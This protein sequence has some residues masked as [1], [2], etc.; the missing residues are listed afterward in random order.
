M[1]EWLRKQSAQWDLAMALEQYKAVVREETKNKV[2]D[3]LVVPTISE[4]DV[5][6]SIKPRGSPA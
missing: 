1:R 2:E 3:E 5:D 6:S 4:M